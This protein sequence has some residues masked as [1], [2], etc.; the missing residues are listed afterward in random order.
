MSENI[1]IARPYAKAVFNI[2]DNSGML[3]EWEKVL[4]SLSVIAEQEDVGYFLKNRTISHHDKCLVIVDSLRVY[5]SFNK[6]IQDICVNFI[7]ILSYYDRLL[8]FREIYCLYK[9]YMNFKLLRVDAIIK[10]AFV[11]SSEQKEVIVDC[12]S[13]RFER[14]VSALFLV[15]EKL[16]GGVLVKV[17]DCVLDASVIGNLIHLRAKIAV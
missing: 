1:T 2:A 7:E 6:T 14:H 13:K 8:C 9:D 12:L 16:L 5:H 15:D 10:V 4:F 3:N 11:L 17:G